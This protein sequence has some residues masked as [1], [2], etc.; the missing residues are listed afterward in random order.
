MENFSL[1][2]SVLCT[3]QIGGEHLV[4]LS[5]DIILFKFKKNYYSTYMY[6][7]YCTLY[8]GSIQVVPGNIFIILCCNP[9]YYSVQLQG[10]HNV[11]PTRVIKNMFVSYF[12]QK[13]NTFCK[14]KIKFYFAEIKLF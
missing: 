1:F 8:P 4:T 11:V 13:K 6:E 12:S 5:S 2:I 10:L 14:N 9:V 3:Q 7:A